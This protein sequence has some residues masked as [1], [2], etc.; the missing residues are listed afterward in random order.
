MWQATPMAAAQRRAFASNPSSECR[1]TGDLPLEDPVIFMQ[2]WFFQNQT[3]RKPIRQPFRSKNTPQP[4]R[5]RP[6]KSTGH[7]PAYITEITVGG[8]QY[9][10]LGHKEKPLGDARPFAGCYNSATRKYLHP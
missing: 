5:T 10:H 8:Q 4:R 3:H 2:W 7:A 1:Q 6:P 9:H